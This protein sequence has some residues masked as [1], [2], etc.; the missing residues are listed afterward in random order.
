MF[1]LSCLKKKL[2]DLSMPP[3][4]SAKIDEKE[5]HILRISVMCFKKVL[6][7]LSINQGLGKHF[8]RKSISHHVFIISLSHVSMLS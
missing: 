5:M 1:I 8:N 2:A 6:G 7:N 4:L 3:T